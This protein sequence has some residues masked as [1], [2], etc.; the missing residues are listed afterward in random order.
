MKHASQERQGGP[1]V[2]STSLSQPRQQ[3]IVLMQTIGFGQILGLVV[4]GGEPVLDPPPEIVREVKLGPR[5]D[6]WTGNPNV[7]CALKVPVVQLFAQLDLLG[8]GTIE[9]LEVHDG[10]P[11][12]LRLRGKAGAR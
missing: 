9:M 3:L 7:N 5:K 4:K 8:T 12:R 10:L 1:E 2:G 11:F 6:I